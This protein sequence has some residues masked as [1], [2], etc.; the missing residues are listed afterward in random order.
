LPSCF[1]W[2]QVL[3][4]EHWVYCTS[5]LTWSVGAGQQCHT[6]SPT[7]P[8]GGHTGPY[9][10]HAPGGARFLQGEHWVYCTSVLTLSA[11]RGSSAAPLHR[12]GQWAV[13]PG[14]Y[15]PHA[16]GG[17][18]FLQGEHW[19]YCTSVLTLSAGA[20]GRATPLHRLVSGRSYR[21][22]IALMLLV[23]PGSYKVNIWY[24][25]LQS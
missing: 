8:M 24:I 9:C 6:S 13:I 20:Q 4:G 25:V 11:G 14:P 7:W 2:S 19:V 5:V 17:A 22:C 1:W 21:A 16:P 3:Q 23:E 12:P 10:A 15:C 18:R